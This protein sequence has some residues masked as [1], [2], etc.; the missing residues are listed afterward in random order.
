[1]GTGVIAPN[2]WVRQYA[3]AAGAAGVTNLAHNGWFSHEILGALR[4][5]RM[6]RDSVAYADVVVLNAGMN[7][8][9]TGRDLY[10][11]AECG[12]A[13]GEACLRHMVVR[14]NRNWDAIVDEIRRLAPEAHILA[15]N[16]YHPLEA[17]DQHFGWSDAV[18]R[19]L[20][21]MNE[22]VESTRGV[23]LVDLHTTFNGVDG[24]DDPIARG[25]LLPDA[26][27]ATARGHDAIAA[28]AIGAGAR[29][30]R[31]RQ[32]AHGAGAP[33]GTSPRS[34]TG[35]GEHTQGSADAGPCRCGGHA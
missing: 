24:L 25:Y 11:R 22:H 7:D 27:H 32:A 3:T 4:R 10:G 30:L 21:A 26:I 23:T 29:T 12:G 5:G 9:F 8:F 33:G 2:G 17:F 34:D 35:L 20:E 16:L 31:A 14:F 6:F 13:D 18:N 28:A 19:H 15:A 1:M